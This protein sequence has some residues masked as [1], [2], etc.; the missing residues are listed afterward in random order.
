MRVAVAPDGI[1]FMKRGVQKDLISSICAVVF[2]HSHQTSCYA[3]NK[4]SA[5]CRKLD[6][7]HAGNDTPRH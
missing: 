5:A 3:Q 1:P 2:S 7:P 4:V 6:Y